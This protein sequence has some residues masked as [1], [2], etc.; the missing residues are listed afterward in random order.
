MK[1]I[2]LK[3]IKKDQ[4]FYEGYYD[5]EI[6][7]I[8]LEDSYVSGYMENE[9]KKLKQWSCKARNINTEEVIDYL[10]TENCEHYGAKLFVDETEGKLALI[11]ENYK[12]EKFHKLTKLSTINENPNGI[13]DT[14]WVLGVLISPPT[15]GKPL[16]MARIANSLNPNGKEGIFNTSE[17]TSFDSGAGFVTL[18][19]KN[20]IYKLEEI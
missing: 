9:G 14:Y 6:K 19:T 13:D 8:A 20:S 11:M 2:H 5:T 18:K 15:I 1:S 16:L 7:L 10:T 12:A 17:I 4:V 3:D